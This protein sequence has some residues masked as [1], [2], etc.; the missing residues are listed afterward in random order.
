MNFSQQSR[1]SGTVLG[2]GIDLVEVARIR[3]AHG[4]HGERFLAKV[5]TAAELEY[6]MAQ[7]DPFPSLAARFAAKE[8]VSKAFGCGIG[9]QIDWHS[10]S[11]GKD[12]QGAPVVIL[13]PSAEAFLLELGGTGVLISLTHTRSLAQAMAA[14]VADPKAGTAVA[15]KTDSSHNSADE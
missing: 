9:G 4:R 1:P 12:A 7:P 2:L 8:A 3:D 13:S 15:Q 11:I 10:V 6:C 14:L 5:Y